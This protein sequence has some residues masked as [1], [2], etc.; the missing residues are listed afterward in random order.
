MKNL[1]L[2]SK[3]LIGVVILAIVG[4]L[5][6]FSGILNKERPLRVSVVTWG[7]YAGGQLWNEGFKASEESRFLKEYGVP[8]EFVLND[9]I[10]SSLKAW[11]AGEVDAHWWTADVFSTVAD[12]LAAYNPKVFMQADWSRGGD[13]IVVVRGINSV[14]DLRGRKIAVAFKTPSHS[15][16]LWALESAGM[17]PNDVQIVEVASAIDAAAAFKA[18]QVDAAVVWAP[19]D[20]GCV[21][22]VPGSTILANTKDAKYIISDVFFAKEEVLVARHDDFVS[23]AEGW[24]KGSALINTDPTAKNRAAEILS[25]G[26]SVSVDYALGAINNVRLTTLGDNINFFNI[27]GNYQGVKGEDIYTKTGRMYQ[28]YGII[29]GSF[30]DWRSVVDLSIVKEVIERG[31][32]TGNMN[33]AEAATTFERP[34]EKMASAPAMATKRVTINF[35]TNVYALDENAMR[36]LD[37]QAA[38]AL[39]FMGGVRVR[40][41]GNT[42]NVGDYQMNMNLSQKRAEAVADYLA[43]T[44][45]FDRNRFVIVG[46]GPDNPVASNETPDGRAKN[47]RTDI[48]LF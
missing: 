15:F 39:R 35:A 30:P 6:W 16:L 20:Q 36:I 28:K 47:R 34:T 14:N 18:G 22:A 7:G 11:E 10:E 26:L 31:K 24:L 43:R 38:D 46:K 32:L 9:D 44:Y 17:T 45:K 37:L 13:A 19:D 23:L 3:V 21:D 40:I 8:V 1:T 2:L 25:T 41:T 42:D 5:L 29:K 4:S 12:E 27:N 33:A 48:E